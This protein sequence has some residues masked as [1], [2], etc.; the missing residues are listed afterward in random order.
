MAEARSRERVAAE[1]NARRE[2]E[3]VDMR[4]ASEDAKVPPILLGFF[5]GGLTR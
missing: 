3:V 4:R 1:E 5:L 2:Q